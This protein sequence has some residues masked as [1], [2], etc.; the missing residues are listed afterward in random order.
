MRLAASDTR[1]KVQPHSDMLGRVGTRERRVLGAGRRW[2]W[3]GVYGVSGVGAWI[4][5]FC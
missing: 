5:G 3:Q 1:F 4:V 2:M